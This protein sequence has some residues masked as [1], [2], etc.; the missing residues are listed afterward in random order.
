MKVLKAALWGLMQSGTRFPCWCSVMKRWINSE[1][2]RESHHQ[3]RESQRSH[4]SGLTQNRRQ[5]RTFSLPDGQ[6]TVLVTVAERP[7][8]H[9]LEV[10]GVN[11]STGHRVAALTHAGVVTQTA[12][13]Q[14]WVRERVAARDPFGL[15]EKERGVKNTKIFKIPSEIQTKISPLVCIVWTHWIKDQHPTEQMH[16][17]VSGSIREHVQHRQRRLKNKQKLKFQKFG[18]SLQK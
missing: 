5:R 7:L 8:G 15:E 1:V 18:N 12:F 3:N 17:L 16:R 6:Q 10:A 9:R 2:E 13:V 14:V 11:P 4:D